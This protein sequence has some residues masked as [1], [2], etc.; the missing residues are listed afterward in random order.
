M[1]AVHHFSSP[2]AEPDYTIHFLASENPDMAELFHPV[3]GWDFVGLMRFLWRK[4]DVINTLDLRDPALREEFGLRTVSGA[5]QK[6]ARQEKRSAEQA[7]QLI[8]DFVIDNPNCTR[9]DIARALN[10]AKSPHIRAQIE[11]LV[12][13]G[14]LART[15]IVRPEGTIEYRYIFVGDNEN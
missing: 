15:Q 5:S 2:R 9:L 12:Y 8:Q 6:P 13:N 1:V 3:D 10:R 4:I 14:V 7:L 11:W